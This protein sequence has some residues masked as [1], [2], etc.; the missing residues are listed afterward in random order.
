MSRF[1]AEDERSRLE[2][3]GA[4]LT[5]RTKSVLVVRRIPI[6]PSSV[7]RSINGVDAQPPT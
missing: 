1:N 7:S 5:F 6:S 3:L 4:L 2:N